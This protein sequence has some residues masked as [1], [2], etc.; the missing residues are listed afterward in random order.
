MRI[1]EHAVGSGLLRTAWDVASDKRG[2]RR[3]AVAQADER[4]PRF[5]FERQPELLILL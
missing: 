2:D 1:D 5:T 3:F 4:I